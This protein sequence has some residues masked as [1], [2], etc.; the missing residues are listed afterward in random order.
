MNKMNYAAS[1][2]KHVASIKPNDCRQWYVNMKG[3]SRSKFKTEREAAIAVDKLLIGR[4]KEP[5]NI[6][7]R[8]KRT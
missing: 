6:L 5:V 7:T 1:Q 3:V 4:G 8:A 2:Y